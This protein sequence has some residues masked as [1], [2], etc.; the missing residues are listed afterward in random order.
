MKYIIFIAASIIVLFSSCEREDAAANKM[1]RG[2]GLWKLDSYIISEYDSLGHIIKENISK[3]PGEIQF[4]HTQ[5]YNGLFGYHACVVIL[6]DSNN[7]KTGYVG[8]YM[9]DRERINIDGTKTLLD[10]WWTINGWK[11]SEQ[12]W[13][14]VEIY[15]APANRSSL[16]K[17]YSLKI[18]KG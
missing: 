3:A 6:N 1:N 15:G 9:T 16:L 8:E 10:G 17:R 7:L 2:N 5:T 18:K 14:K 4:Y 11:G 12:E 13:I